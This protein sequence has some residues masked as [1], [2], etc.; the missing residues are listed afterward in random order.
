MKLTLEKDIRVAA[1]IN[2]E[3]FVGLEDGVLYQHMTD[4]EIFLFIKSKNEEKELKIRI[5]KEPKNVDS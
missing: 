3:K 1:D 4:D 2:G 5:I